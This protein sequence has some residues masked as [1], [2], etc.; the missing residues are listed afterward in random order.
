MVSLLSPAFLELLAGGK[1]FELHVFALRSPALNAMPEGPGSGL[2]IVV[3]GLAAAG[4]GSSVLPTWRAMWML[5]WTK[6]RA[7]VVRG[8]LGWESWVESR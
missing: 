6:C 4:D 7:V 5:G 8:W 2:G 1:S 3:L